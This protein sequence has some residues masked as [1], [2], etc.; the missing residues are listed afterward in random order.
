MKILH[1]CDS[2]IGGTGTYLAELLPHQ[3]T[4][5]GAGNVALL[6]PSSHLSH[7]EAAIPQSGVTILT[8]PR[9]N[10]LL[11]MFFLL[12][13]YLYY[14]VN[15][16]PKV[17]HAHSFGA[18]VITR[19]T[20]LFS[21]I[22]II[23]CPHGWAF[24]M[25]GPRWR[26]ALIERLEYL[27]SLATDRLI[28][29]SGHEYQCARDI[30]I[31]QEK[32][33]LVRSGIAVTPPKVEPKSW[34]D[35]RL[36]LLFVGRFDEQKGLDVL[37]DAIAPLGDRVVLRTIGDT[38][39]SKGD[40]NPMRP[41]SFVEYLGWLDREQVAAHMKSAD[42]LVVPSRWEGFGLVALEAMRLSLPVIVSRVGGLREIV[43]DGRYGLCFE[44]GHPGALRQCIET[45]QH[46]S[47]AQWRQLARQRFM[48]SFTSAS[49]TRAIDGLYSE[50]SAEGGLQPA[51]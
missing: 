7:L 11:G 17:V 49:M 34:T 38:V 20:K 9:P 18:G 35:Q 12:F 23:Y 10:R 40:F 33:R 42:F 45:I 26:N 39:V 21:S 5:Y 44:P 2:I 27:L 29:I 4:E 8:F 24:N 41:L 25:Q 31:P 13:V 15:L 30:G 22:P 51:R 47:I 14:L 28:L 43:D 6:M 36:K 3:G 37:L 1:V 32:L 16:Q 50:L 46:E 48:D 19:I